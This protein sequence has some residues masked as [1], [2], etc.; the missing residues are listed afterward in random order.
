VL[1]LICGQF[2]SFGQTISDILLSNG[3]CDSSGFCI[4]GIEGMPKP[5][6]F[7]F[8]YRRIR[9]YD[10][11]TKFQDDIYHGTIDRNRET[12]VKLTLP[13]IR[14]EHFMLALGGKY[15]VEEFRFENPSINN[16][17]FYSYLEDKPLR[18]M[19]LTAYL[20]QSLKG[21]KFLVGRVNT[22][23]SGDID[24]SEISN[25]FRSTVSVIYGQKKSATVSWG[26]GITYNNT[27]GRQLILPVLTYNK[28][29]TKKLSARILLPV[30]FE[31]NYMINEKNLLRW[32]NRLSGDNYYINSGP[33]APQNLYLSKSDFF[34]TLTYEREVYDF[35]WVSANLGYHVNY[36]FDLST[37]NKLL[38][39]DAP[40]IS[41]DIQNATSFQLSLF[42]VP[43]KK[44]K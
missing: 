25:Y 29:I 42:M 39:T 3:V 10:I 12:T 26:A 16:S 1:I 28:R 34:S 41:N 15:E 11:K 17:N 4:R 43:P 8:R 31:L 30:N 23:L 21:D 5:K 2:T 7:E 38:S 22:R 35:I 33:L 19:G 14:K 6:G 18:S 36:K 20:A 27:F 13:I 9:D 44:S 40:A 32:D 37:T 24:R